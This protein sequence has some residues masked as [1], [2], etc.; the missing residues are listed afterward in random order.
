[1]ERLQRK[2]LEVENKLADPAIYENYGSTFHQHFLKDQLSIKEE[3]NE[4][5]ET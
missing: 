2:L 4:L 3:L 5:E 1:M